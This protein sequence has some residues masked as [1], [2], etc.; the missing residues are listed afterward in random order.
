MLRCLGP[1]WKE[2]ILTNARETFTDDV[3]VEAGRSMVGRAGGP[4]RYADRPTTIDEDILDESKTRKRPRQAQDSSPDLDAVRFD[5][6]DTG[7]A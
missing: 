1:R 3:Y 6:A 2:A 7:D 5:R 4:V